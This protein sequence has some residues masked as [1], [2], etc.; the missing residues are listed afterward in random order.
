[1]SGANT[2]VPVPSADHVA[3]VALAGLPE[4][5]PARLRFLLDH[6]GSPTRALRAVRRGDA[7]RQMRHTSSPRGRE[8]LAAASAGWPA[9]L[10]PDA[11]RRLLVTRGARVWLDG[12]SEYPIVDVPPPPPALL[13]AEGSRPDALDA[14][15]VAIVGTRSATP[16]G[17]DDARELAAT[18]VD[19][20]VTVVSGLAL[21]IDGAAHRGAVDGGG[22]TIGVVATGLDVEY[23]R[24]HRTLYAAVRAH[25]LVLGETGYGI[26]PSPGRFPVRNRIIAALADVVVVVEAT[27]SG[28]ARITAE[29]ALRYQRMVFA[30]PGS[31]RNAAAAGTNALLADGA[32]PLTEWSDVLIALG[33]TPGSRRAPAARAAPDR[34][35][36][37]ILDALAGEPGS[38]EQI[39]AR[40]GFPPETIALA[41]GALEQAGWVTW[42]QG[43]V[44][45]R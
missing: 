7:A 19:A 23:P 43:L 39:A 15:R 13:L 2:A 25:G 20:G 33:M 40:T 4:I 5:G 9:Q 42:A 38:P 3:A 21:G 36:R 35:G 26:G 14:P 34:S 45:P 10:D 24:R 30:V 28:G 31:R 29:Q 18:L 1:M 8:A 37:S 6:Y 16:H 27:I 12:E 17:I 22:L 32:Q 11:T 44:W 41:V